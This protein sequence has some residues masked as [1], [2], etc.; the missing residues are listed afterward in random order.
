MSLQDLN[1][2]RL[3]GGT[4]LSLQIGHRIS[5]DLNFFSEKSFDNDGIQRL[6]QSE[7]EQFELQSMSGTGFSCFIQ[8]IKC[9]FYNWSVRFIREP[10]NKD[11]IRMC[12]LE[13]IVAFKLDAIIRRKKKTFGILMLFCMFFH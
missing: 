8:G 3:V 10:I 5:V 9:D 1:L 4:S 11:G 2:F 12:S 13:D 7:T 6:L